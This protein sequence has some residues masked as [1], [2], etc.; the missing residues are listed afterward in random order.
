MDSATYIRD[1]VLHPGAYIVEGFP[2]GLM[3]IDFRDQLAPQD[4][5][6]VVAYLLTLK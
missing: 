4:L 5:D 2:D 6:A 3:P 1:S